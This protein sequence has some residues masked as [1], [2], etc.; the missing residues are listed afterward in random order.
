MS[1]A[2]EL[3]KGARIAIV[4]DAWLPQVNGVVRTWRRVGEELAAIGYEPLFLTPEGFRTW[5]LPTYPE[6]RLAL[7]ARG[8]VRRTLA[9]AR[10]DAIHVATEGPLGLFAR[11]FCLTRRL[12]FTT[13]FHTRFHDYVHARVRIPPAWTLAALRRFHGPASATFVP[14]D[15]M[16]RE[17][18]AAGFEDLVLWTRGVDADV[19][20]PVKAAD[21]A[22]ARPV[23]LYVGRIAVEKNLR[24]FL[25]L[26]LPGTKLLVGDGPQRAQ[27]ERAY[28]AAVFA[29]AKFGEELAACYAS[30]DVF[31]F[32][33]RTDTFGLVLLEALASGTPVAA[34][35]VPG[36]RDIVTTD[37]VGAIDEDLGAA[38]RAALGKSAEACRRHALGF[39]WRRAAEV[40]LSRLA[41]IPREVPGGAIS[42]NAAGSKR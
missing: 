2:G 40:L 24:A 12:P 10:P 34:Y 27:L 23:F 35:P 29:G 5:P 7:T 19:F 25:D 38:A 14:T 11:S 37:A 20:H 26:E 6:I 30:A 41:A 32:P 17:L 28:P 18:A 13:S 9:E 42:P 3:P 22:L 8:A 33:S 1:V 36:P 31:V 21:P 39:S 16:L 4:T 15:S